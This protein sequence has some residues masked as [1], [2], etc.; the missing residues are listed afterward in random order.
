MQI[1]SIIA[2]N[3]DQSCVR[4]I[5]EEY[6]DRRDALCSG[7]NDCGWSVVPPK[8]TMFLWA[9][10]PKPFEHL[11][12]LEFSKIMTERAKVAV[13][14]GIGFGPHGD[15]FVRFALVENRKR[16][17]Q[18]VRG[19]RTFIQEASEAHTVRKAAGSTH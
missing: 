1:A 12:S 13:S 10:I 6:R 3:E 8:A 18:A 14:P 9:P 17:N 19:I 16:I 4:H 11:G 15:D 5:V 7:L 2:L